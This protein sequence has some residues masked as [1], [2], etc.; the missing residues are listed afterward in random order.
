[1]IYLRI[2]YSS[3]SRHA[4]KYAGQVCSEFAHYMF[5]HFGARVW[6]LGAMLDEDDDVAVEW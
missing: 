3:N 6:I 5:R 1:M 2:V 4:E